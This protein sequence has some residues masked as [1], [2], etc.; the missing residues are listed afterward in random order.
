MGEE[1][2]DVH[3]N[4]AQNLTVSQ[5]VWLTFN[6]VAREIQVKQNRRWGTANCVGTTGLSPPP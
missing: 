5:T 2:S 6:I 4:L 1:L 3:I